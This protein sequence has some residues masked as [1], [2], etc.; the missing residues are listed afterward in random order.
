MLANDVINHGGITFVHRVLEET[1]ASV[2]E[3]AR[4]YFAARQVFD[5]DG[6]WQE[7]EALDRVAPVEAQNAMY[8]E[9]R[10]LLDR[11]VRWVPTT[12][13]GVLDVSKLIEDAHPVVRDLTPMIPEM[14]LG[15]E[16]QRLLELTAQYTKI[17][18]LSRW[19]SGLRLAWTSTRCSISPISPRARSRTRPSPGCI[20]RCPNGSGS[21]PC[22][23]R[24]RTWNGWTGGQH[25]PGRQF[26]RT[27]T[28]PWLG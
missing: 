13:G 23:P 16:R 26:A 28:A 22:S 8:L 17:E 11:A 21:M 1:G 14:L 3:T 6:L 5:L 12:R 27:C 4:A 20:S 18:L 25:L 10:R 19:R 2:E 24:S 7:I 15:T 9:V